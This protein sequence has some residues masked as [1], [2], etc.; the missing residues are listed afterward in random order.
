MSEQAKLDFKVFRRLVVYVKSYRRILIFSLLCTLALSTLT[1]LR[2]MVIGSMVNDYIIKHQDASAL[3]KW[4]IFLL[5]MLI[6]E[7]VFQFLNSYFSNL[8]AQSV[9]RDIRQRLFQHII[10]FR[11]RYFD[12]TPIGNLV[13]RLVSDIEAISEVFSSGLIDILGDLLMLIVVVVMMTVTNWQLSLMTLIPIPLLLIATRV[14]ARAM[15]NSFQSERLQVTRLNTFVQEHITGMSIVQLFNREKQ[16]QR[17]FESINNDHKQAQVNAVWAFSIFFPVV[18]MLASLSVALMLVWGAFQFLGDNQPD[19]GHLYEEIFAF[20]LWINMLFRPIRQLADKFNILQRGIVRAERVFEVLDMQEDVQH[21]GAVK[22]MDFNRD[23]RFEHVYFSY[24]ADIRPVDI[25]HKTLDNGL[26]TLDDRQE[27]LDNGLEEVDDRQ[28]TIDNRLETVDDGQKTLPHQ[29]ADEG[30]GDAAWVL[31]DINLTIEKGTTVAFVGATGAGKTSIVN[32]LGRFYEY[33]RGDI[34]IGDTDIQELELGYLRKNIAIVLQDVF[35]FSDTILN[36]ITLG[37]PNITREQVIEAAKAVSAHEFIE[38]LPNGYDYEVGE[39]GGVLSVG[40]RQLLAFI[41][42]YV[43][44][45]HILIL[46]E[47]TSSVD[48]ESEELIQ[49]A[50]EKLTKGRT[51]IVIAHRLS[52][53][54][55]ADNIVVMDHGRIVETGT[56]N[57][58][59]ETEGYY[60]KL[61]DIQFAEKK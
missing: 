57:Q 50:T 42:A 51:S 16:E 3:L 40:Q 8:L 47:A 54:Q 60:R 31:K 9:I 52:T 11:M 17:E 33:Q 15:R 1:P 7:G 24:K 44:N 22:Q 56:H 23:I 19:P 58:L 43:Y 12:K 13:T 4:T 20:T 32:L 2:P 21:E 26:E 38:K 37:D 36:N 35:L 28:E 18:E 53:I 45:P 61:Y 39:R 34:R 49:R 10:T 29:Q 6:F 59:L 25:G 30:Q 48:N 27:T 46:D 41:R 14:F 55:N 5:V